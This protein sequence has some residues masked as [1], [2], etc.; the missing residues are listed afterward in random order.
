V[1]RALVA[2]IAMLCLVKKRLA[3]PLPSIMLPLLRVGL[4]LCNVSLKKSSGLAHLV[5][6]FG[7]FVYCTGQFAT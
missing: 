3:P 2:L 4:A 7:R 5:I 6:I 1:W